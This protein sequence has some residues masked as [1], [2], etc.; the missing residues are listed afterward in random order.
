MLAEELLELIHSRRSV[1]RFHA[2]PIAREILDRLIEAA[3]WSPTAGN[4]QDW[5]FT[6]VTSDAVRKKMA[7]VAQTAWERLLAER[8]AEVAEDFKRYARS[9]EWFASAPALV[10]VSV[11]KPEGFLTYLMGDAAGEVGGGKASAAMAAQNIMLMAH[12]LGLASCCLSGPLAAQE[13]L[14][15]VVGLDLHDQ[16]VCLIALGYPDEKPAP[17]PRKPAQEVTHYIE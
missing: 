13:R 8:A 14:Q 6:L 1:R 11:R 9:F 4:R 17:P 15:Q 10:V 2:Q 16:I 5:T 3:I 7:Q 12:A